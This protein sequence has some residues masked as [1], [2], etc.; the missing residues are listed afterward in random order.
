MKKRK[1]F[2]VRVL[3]VIL[4]LLMVLSVISLPTLKAKAE[5]PVNTVDAF[6]ERCYTVTLDR[7]SDPDGF[8]DWKGQLL[9]GK[10][11]GIEV[12]YGFLFSPEYTK[13]NKSNEDYVKDLYMLFLGRTPDE[14]GFNDWVGQLNE[15]KSRLDVY[16]GFANSVEFYNLCT[17]CGITAGR[18]VKGYDRA[19]NNN[20]NLFVER[21][22]KTCLGRVGDREGQK[23]WVEKLITKQIS[24]T[25]CARSF[26]QST[27]Y[28]N[29]GLYDDN[30]VENLYLAMMGRSSDEEGKWNWVDALENGM[31]RDEVFAGFANSQEFAN[32][33]AKYKIEKGSYTAK[34][35]SN[36]NLPENTES[37]KW[38]RVSRTDYS[39]GDYAISKY[40]DFNTEISR[41]RYDKNG[42]YLGYDYRDETMSNGDVYGCNREYNDDG[43]LQVDS[44][45]YYKTSYSSDKTKRTEYSYSDEWNTVLYY[46]VYNDVKYTYDGPDGPY[47]DYHPINGTFY[48]AEGNKAGSIVYTY[49][50]DNRR[51]KSTQYL[52]GK[53]YWTDE[54]EYYDKKGYEGQYVKKEDETEY[55]YDGTIAERTIS[56]YDEDENLIKETFYEDNALSYYIVCEYDSKGNKTKQTSYDASNTATSSNFYIYDYYGNLIKETEYHGDHLYLVS[57]TEYTYDGNNQ[58]LKAVKYDHYDIVQEFWG[59]DYSANGVITRYYYSDGVTLHE[60]KYEMDDKEY[61]TKL[62]KSIDGSVYYW[63][64]YTYEECPE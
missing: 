33:C 1:T 49:Y 21:L 32:L 57:Y 51:K 2:D 64:K 20:V 50:P 52:D 55:K 31:T 9:N 27:E 17:E 30:Y 59:Y 34:D 13:K 47:T 11:V 3:S 18:Y 39:N 19:T 12:A 45:F 46:D 40:V 7:G 10:A 60:H 15:G 5:E 54:F 48:D 35:V 44:E 4:S 22:Y 42:N 36:P 38:Y 16:A 29:K 26:I 41:I 24:G 6:V 8:A 61:T 23:N 62:T 14:A 43:T 63:E 25:E 58:M 53:L 56:E 37:K 28:V